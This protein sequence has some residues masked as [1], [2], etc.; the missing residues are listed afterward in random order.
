MKCKYCGKVINEDQMYCSKDCE[1]NTKT[2]LEKVAKYKN[3]YLI[4]VF[5]P[6]LL[7]PVFN[8]VLYDLLIVFFLG[9][10]L[11]L[12][13]FSTPQ[14]VNMIGICKSQ[15]IVRVIGLIL[16]IISL[17]CCYLVSAK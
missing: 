12:F 13:P 16:M 8:N 10:F 4:I 3:L 11:I 2:Y 14:L 5:L 15:K 7:M 6:V 17:I 1:K 9:G